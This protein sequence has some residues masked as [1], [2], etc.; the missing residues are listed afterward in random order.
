MGKGSAL[1]TARN[2]SMKAMAKRCQQVGYAG[3]LLRQIVSSLM[4]SQHLSMCE[5]F[6]PMMRNTFESTRSTLV[7]P[8]MDALTPLVMMQKVLSR[9]LWRD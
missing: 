4:L 8:M 7:S 2:E 6:L 3:D 1:N 5:V 9:H